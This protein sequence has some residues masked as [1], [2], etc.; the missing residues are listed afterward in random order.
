[1]KIR[2]QVKQFVTFTLMLCLCIGAGF[3]NTRTAK[4]EP[5][6]FYISDLQQAEEGG[7]YY[8][9]FT[10]KETTKCAVR[11][12]LMEQQDVKVKIFKGETTSGKTVH[13]ATINAFLYSDWDNAY[14]SQTVPAKALDPGTYTVKIT[15]AKA[16]AYILTFATEYSEPGEIDIKTDP[17]IPANSG[18]KLDGDPTP[19]PDP[20]PTPDP[21]PGDSDGNTGTTEP[22]QPIKNGKISKKELT[23]LCGCQETLE[24]QEMEIVGPVTWTSSNKYVA[25][26]D[27]NG[28]VT[29]KK[30][31]TTRIEAT[32]KNTNGSNK[33]FYCTVTVK[34]NEY[35]KSQIKV[36]SV[37]KKQCKVQVYK[38]S[39]DK[40][41]NLVLECVAANNTGRKLTALKNLKINVKDADGKALAAY[42]TSTKKLTVA[43]GKIKTFKI[44]I[45]K[46]QLKN[47]ETVELAKCKCSVSSK[48]K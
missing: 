43:N 15:F 5:A 13:E 3:L 38:F 46:S 18:E 7:T 16:T 42:K 14:S 32:A 22:T 12:R 40:D 8:Y 41:G 17:N 6:E 23:L 36:S 11:I 45:K 20:T 28:T 33:Y 25:S 4:A 21:T 31:G 48:Y 10:L 44:T 29:A 26:V 34:K 35:K 37:P 1:M 24:I 47:Q 19:A 2:N 27:D 39:Y 9:R 30:A